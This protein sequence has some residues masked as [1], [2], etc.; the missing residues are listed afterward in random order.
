MP[1]SFWT[2]STATEPCWIATPPPEDEDAFT[3]A[4]LRFFSDA[5]L[6]ERLQAEAPETARDW[7]DVAS[8]KHM[9]ALYRAMTRD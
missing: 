9:A 6:R 7:S 8:A 5:A 2:I 1:S 3:D 4:V